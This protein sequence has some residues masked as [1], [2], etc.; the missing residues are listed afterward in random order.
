M[1]KA[2]IMLPISTANWYA[3]YFRH[4][5]GSTLYSTTV[6]QQ[7]WPTQLFHSSYGLAGGLVPCQLGGIVSGRQ[8]LSGK[9]RSITVL[10]TGPD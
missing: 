7:Y 5:Y 6:A 1:L 9:V 3:I 8:C 2:M 4:L 10:V